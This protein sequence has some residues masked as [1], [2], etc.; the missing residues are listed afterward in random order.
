MLKNKSLAKG[1]ISVL[2][3]NLINL[4]FNL[5][6]NFLLPKY[7]SVESYAGI[8]TFQLYCV[9]IGV[10]HLGYVDGM[11]LKYGGKDSSEINR[12]DLS[13]NLSTLR[14][15]QV[16][17]TLPALLLGV[18]FKNII[19]IFFACSITPLN[20]TQYFKFFYQAVGEFKR[21]GH[22]MNIVTLA[23]FTINIILLFVIKSDSLILFL[24]CYLLVN[25]VIWGFLE[26]QIRKNTEIHGKFWY[27]SIT[28]LQS[29]IKSGILLMVGNFTST[30]LSSMD[31]WF[32]KVLLRTIDFAQY[33]FGVSVESV[34][35][36]AITPITVTL[37]NFFC[38]HK[39]DCDLGKKC[40]SYVT[41][42][43][44]W[45]VSAAFPAKFIIEV[46]LTEYI[47]SVTVI[48]YLFAAQ[49]IYIVVKAIYVNL[50][51]AKEMQCKYF[52]KLCVVIISGVMF[53]EVCFRIL[54]NKEAF[55][56]GTLL[57]AVVWLVLSEWDF[58]QLRYN[59][60]ECL[61]LLIEI[62]L[63]IVCGNCFDS[64]IGFI[65][66]ICV[67]ACLD[68]VVYKKHIKELGTHVLYA[69]KYKY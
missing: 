16:F 47:E 61:Y 9:Y 46:Y 10:L 66:Y 5:L 60:L 30:L 52:A 42:F 3:A 43:A 17:I 26:I 28:E 64:I 33:S 57:S 59:L 20:M 18:V 36:V 40:K 49:I 14:M 15:F 55:A 21:Y 45:V 29:S 62:V 27:I 44:T 65:V 58:K 38:K 8:K 56:I 53:N 37:Y 35:N 6:T 4:V 1:M 51:K 31:R 12:E 25:I 19:M 24:L 32:V 67:T 68:L 23:T 39:N 22:V 41:I 7:L 2:S 13:K 54:N 11:F 50:Y 63:L 48:F 69:L 34:L